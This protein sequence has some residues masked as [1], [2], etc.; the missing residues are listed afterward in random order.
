MITATIMK[1]TKT[2]T[3]ISIGT[4]K[5]IAIA[6]SAIIMINKARKRLP[7][8]FA[9]PVIMLPIADVAS[10]IAIV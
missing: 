1:G 3:V 7:V 9:S 10:N 5:S 8:V 6:K 2:G 4:F